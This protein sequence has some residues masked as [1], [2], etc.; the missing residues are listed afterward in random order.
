V[1]SIAQPGNAVISYETYAL[2]RDIVA[3]KP[4]PSSTMKNMSRKG[5][6]YEATGVLDAS[7]A[8]A[9]IF[10]EH[11]TGLDFYF[12]PSALDK[13]SAANIC[14]LFKYALD[15]LEKK[16]ASAHAGD[17]AGVS[18]I[19]TMGD[20]LDLALSKA[21]KLPHAAREKIERELLDRI[22]VMSRLRAEINVGLRELD[23]GIG[24]PLDVEAL[25]RQARNREA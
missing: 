1:E 3:A 8:M 17:P 10:S 7:G 4:L 5:A 11:M 13:V 23:Q 12:D 15:A 18:Y 16:G 24:S 19:P 14:A 22:E 9:E 6:P 20:M 21:A 25:M 2:V